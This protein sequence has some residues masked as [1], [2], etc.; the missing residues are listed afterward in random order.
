[1]MRLRPRAAHGVL[2]ESSG[3]ACPQSDRAVAGNSSSGRETA[4]MDVLLILILIAVVLWAT[5][6]LFV[7]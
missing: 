6:H 4:A 5:G 3:R 2:G 1:M 7:H